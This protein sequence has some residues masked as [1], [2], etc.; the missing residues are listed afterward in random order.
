MV[1]ICES[2]FPIQYKPVSRLKE[3]P[4]I[5]NFRNITIQHK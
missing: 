4:L 2:Q 3:M 1:E 5:S